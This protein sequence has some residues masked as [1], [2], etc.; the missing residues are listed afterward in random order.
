MRVRWLQQAPF[1]L[2]EI[3]AYIARN[4][5]AAE[6][7]LKIIEAV[8]L[9]RAQQGIGRAGRVPDTKELVVPGLP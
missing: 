2:D 7:I 6:V 5:T 1:D 3:E 9:L 8:S 4:T